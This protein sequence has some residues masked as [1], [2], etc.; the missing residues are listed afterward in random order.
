MYRY[1]YAVPFSSFFVVLKS[2]RRKNWMN[3]LNNAVHC[4]YCWLTSCPVFESWNTL[5]LGLPRPFPFGVDHSGYG[6]NLVVSGYQGLSED[7]IDGYTFVFAIVCFFGGPMFSQVDNLSPWI[8]LGIDRNLCD[9][10]GI[11]PSW[12]FSIQSRETDWIG[13]TSPFTTH[14]ERLVLLS[15]HWT[16]FPE[17]CLRC[18]HSGSIIRAIVPPLLNQGT[19]SFRKLR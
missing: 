11:P 16:F 12:V 15:N 18:F 19:K 9:R 2:R 6:S 8:D 10:D 7:S 14:D 5:A 17:D 4:A 1:T 3:R 13:G